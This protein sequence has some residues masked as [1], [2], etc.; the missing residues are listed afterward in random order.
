M[1]W[2]KIAR[3]NTAAIAFVGLFTSMYMLYEYVTGGEIVCALVSGC[4]VVRASGWAWPLGIPLPLF[5]V[6]FYLAV[7]FW[8][9]IRA[10]T[11]TPRWFLMLGRINIV[12]GFLISILLTFV[13]WLDIKQFCF[14]CLVSAGCS[15]LI[16][17]LMFFDRVPREQEGRSTQELRN[18][19]ITLLLFLVIGTPMFLWLTNYLH[20]G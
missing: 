18:Y 6:L 3:L 20:N 12:L 14:W 11:P 2:A 10:T 9:V 4:E 7:F 5:G 17:I 8:L 15:A 19:F 1:R 16:F 13:E